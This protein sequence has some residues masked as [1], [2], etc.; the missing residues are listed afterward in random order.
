MMTEAAA[1]LFAVERVAEGRSTRPGRDFPRLAG[2][3]KQRD[4][5]FTLVLSF[6]LMRRSSRELGRAGDV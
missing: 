1:F 2:D 4:A 3:T 6:R 5:R